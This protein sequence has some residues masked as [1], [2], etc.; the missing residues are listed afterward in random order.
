[1]ISTYGQTDDPRTSYMGRW[2][3]EYDD[4]GQLVAWQDP[5]GQRVEYQY[6][7]LGKRVTVTE[8]GV[9]TDYTANN[10]NQYTQVGDTTYAFDLDGNLIREDLAD[11]SWT[12]Y[13]YNDENRLIATET[14]DGKM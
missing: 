9:V 13:T 6:D 5:T 8:V 3:H 12:A 4:L 2:E 14:S 10:L 7:G 1:M 11:G